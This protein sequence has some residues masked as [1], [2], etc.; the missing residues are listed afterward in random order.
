MARSGRVID[1][2]N[3]KQVIAQF[4]RPSV[5]VGD[6]LILRSQEEGVGV[7]AYFVVREVLPVEADGAEQLEMRPAELTVI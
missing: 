5:V 7:I 6:R 3:S 1:V 4:S 2:I